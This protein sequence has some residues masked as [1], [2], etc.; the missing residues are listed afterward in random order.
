[1]ERKYPKYALC[2]VSAVLIRDNEILL[3]RRSYPP[4]KG[5]WSLPGGVV[6]AG[7]SIIE[8][9]RRELYEE[10]GIV[11]EPVGILWVLNNVVYD[12]DGRVLYHYVIID[13]LFNSET[14]KGDVAPGGDV[15]EVRW[16][17]IDQL[18]SM[19]DVSR[20]VLKLIE[21]IKRHGLSTIPIDNVDHFTKEHTSA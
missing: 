2:A 16:F 11:A 9:A 15:S 1:M 6:E 12:Q 18:Y 3:V 5:K 13:V 8:A 10:T 4:G 14:I 19:K 21:H 20:T 7:E 17:N